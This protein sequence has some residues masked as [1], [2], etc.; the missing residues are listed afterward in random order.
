MLLHQHEALVVRLLHEQL[1]RLIVYD[2]FKRAEV[3]VD[4]ASSESIFEVARDS[5]HDVPLLLEALLTQHNLHLSLAGNH[6]NHLRDLANELTGVCEN[7]HLGFH[8][9]HV[10]FHQ[11]WHDKSPSLATS[12]HGLEGEVIRSVLHDVRH[13]E[14]LDE[15]GLEV[16]ELGEA[17][18]D[19]LRH[20]KRL[21]SCL[22]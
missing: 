4:G 16:V 21:P 20:L 6:L 10:Y 1:V 15:R 2:H 8:H 11:A 9:A 3:K 17:S 14:G 18:H 19:V 13:T 5:D 22:A 7:D 12:I